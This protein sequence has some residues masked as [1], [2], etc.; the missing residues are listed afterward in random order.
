MTVS[1]GEFYVP[2][3]ERTIQLGSFT[4]ANLTRILILVTGLA[5]FL[6][7]RPSRG[8][9]SQ[10]QRPYSPQGWLKRG[11]R[12]VGSEECKQCVGSRRRTECESMFSPRQRS[13]SSQNELLACCSHDQKILLIQI[14]LLFFHRVKRRQTEGDRTYRQAS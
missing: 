7:R 11:R 5:A 2:G 12:R 13:T 9:V 3:M 14:S 8:T 6:A 4:S 10:L 1:I